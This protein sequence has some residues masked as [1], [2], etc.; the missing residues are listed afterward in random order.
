MKTWITLLLISTISV[1]F[2]QEKDTAE[3]T[4]IWIPNVV[5]PD[6]HGTDGFV[7][8]FDHPIQEVDKFELTVFNRWGEIIHESNDPKAVWRPWEDDEKIPD[9]VYVWK[10]T[11]RHIEDLNGDGLLETDEEITKTGHFTYLK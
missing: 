9:G 8:Q 7:V 6:M 1:S 4:T 10:V 5:G 3:F 2:A 11:Y